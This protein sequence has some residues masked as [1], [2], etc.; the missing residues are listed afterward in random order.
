MQDRDFRLHHVESVSFLFDGEKF[1]IS[2]KAEYRQEL[3]PN[4][5]VDLKK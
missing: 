2:L 1:L 4:I 5:T 3:L